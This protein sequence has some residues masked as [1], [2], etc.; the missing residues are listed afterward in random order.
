MT[1]AELL[2]ELTRR[3]VKLTVN[4]D[5]LRYEAPRGA[6]TPDL[7]EAMR[8]HKPALEA[9]L[10]PSAWPPGLGRPDEWPLE[11]L[12]SLRRYHRPP[13]LD[14]PHAIL[15][16]LVAK[17]VLTPR[18]PG[19][20]LHVFTGLAVVVLDSEPERVVIFEP[21]EVRPLGPAAAPLP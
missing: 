21:T 1:L 10:Q 18:G 17:R 3:G 8:Q 12:H 7:L 13:V 6:V 9:L 14:C 2:R 11:C 16:P 15:F 20:L 4:G 19:K 5:H